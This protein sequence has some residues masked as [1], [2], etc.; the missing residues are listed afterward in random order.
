MDITNAIDITPPESDG[1]VY[2]IEETEEQKSVREQWQ[3]DIDDKIA[4]DE[5]KA[6]AREA[7]LAKFADLGFTQEELSA[8]LG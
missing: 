3:K 2:L 7:V 6:L 4:S 5:A 1:P 8:L